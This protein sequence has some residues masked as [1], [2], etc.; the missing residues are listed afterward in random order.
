MPTRAHAP[1]GCALE[2]NTMQTS[3]PPAAPPRAA[4]PEHLQ[5]AWRRCQRA[6]LQPDSPLPA[7]PD[8]DSALY[9]LR[10]RHYAVELFFL[11]V[12]GLAFEEVFPQDVRRGVR[13]HAHYQ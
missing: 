8:S 3:A 2:E 6:G 5:D 11:R 13:G 9:A 1:R 4:L 12:V 10:Q 7:Q